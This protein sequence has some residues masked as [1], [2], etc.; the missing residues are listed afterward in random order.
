MTAKR[1]PGRPKSTK[2][3]RSARITVAFYP[4]EY[5]TITKAAGDSVGAFIREAALKAARKTR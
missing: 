2:G 3:Q 4:D 5:D 1:K